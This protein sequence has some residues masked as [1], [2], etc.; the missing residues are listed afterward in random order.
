[1]GVENVNQWIIIYRGYTPA[2]L[3]ADQALCQRWLA[4]PFDS[5]TQG[6]K[7]YQRSIQG[8]VDRLTAIQRVMNEAAVAN[9]PA[10]GQMDASGGIWGA[11]GSILGG[12]GLGA[13]GY[14]NSWDD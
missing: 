7:A 9:Q 6:P 12:G 2:Q 1:M 8:F 13:D 3:L 14:P 5:Q 11:N 4:N 10:W